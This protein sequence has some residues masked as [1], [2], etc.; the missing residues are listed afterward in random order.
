MTAILKPTW[1]DDMKAESDHRRMAIVASKVS[2]P[3]SKI[4]LKESQVNGARMNDSILPHKV[5]D[6]MQGFRNGD[7]FPRPV[8][9]K[10]PSGYVILS[11]NQRCEAIRRLIANGEIAKNVE[12]EVYLVDTK[13]RM[14]LDLVA[15][16]ANATHGEGMAKEERIQHAADFVRRRGMKVKDAAAIFV[17]A[18]TSINGHIRAER[19]RQQLQRAGV[20]AHR[21]VNAALLP[22]DKLSY[23]E[24][25][26]VKIGALVAQHSPT[27]E[28]IKQVVATT[29]RE[30]TASGR[31]N[32]I[33]KFE[34][35]LAQEAQSHNGHTAHDTNG[36]LRVS[37][38]RRDKFLSLMSRLANFLESENAG[39]PFSQY[40]ELQITTKADLEKA[41]DLSKRVRY[42]L[43]V[44]K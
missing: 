25:A 4:D 3:F 33:K 7:T 39:E 14:L 36:H 16:S 8:V 18:E 30:S 1:Y 32:R 19:V 31:L 2:I 5:E 34:K 10:T 38:P 26:Q 21:I 11:G 44:V 6:Y 13:D 22:L 41:Q 24:S 37:R 9:H 29:A 40:E 43:G 23:D 27:A 17:V 15:C 12:I 28:R 20:D 35:E 42:R